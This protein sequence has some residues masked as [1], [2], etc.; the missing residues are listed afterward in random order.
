MKKILFIIIGLIVLGNIVSA[1]TRMPQK[2]YPPWNYENRP[3][4]PMFYFVPDGSDST[5]GKWYFWNPVK[6]LDSLEVNIEELG[7]IE[8]AFK[9]TTKAQVDR[10]IENLDGIQDTTKAQLDVLIESNDAI[11]DTGKSQT[12]RML[13]V[14]QDIEN[15]IDTSNARISLIVESNDAIQD[16]NKAQTDRVLD[17]INGLESL[18]SAFKDTNKSQNDRILDYVNGLESN[19]S[20]LKDTNKS[21]LD[22]LLNY[23]NELEGKIDTL[24]NWFVNVTNNQK[25][26]QQLSSAYLPYIVYKDSSFGATKDTAKYK[27]NYLYYKGYVEIYNPNANADTV[28]IEGYNLTKSDWSSNAFGLKNLSLGYQETNNA[29]VVIPAT[30]AYKYEV[31]H[32]RPYY[33][34]VRTLSTKARASNVSIGFC[35]VN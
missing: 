30:T 29:V 27:F 10:V 33:I 22:R 19:G 13:S 14:T 8:D 3:T 9:D 17:Y 23:V 5:V 4:T 16:T 31:T 1:Q 32:L 15:A 12:D 11:Q 21:Q 6:G 25:N 18:S 2:I 35:G 28:A 20:A 24:K 26:G 34:R 7:L